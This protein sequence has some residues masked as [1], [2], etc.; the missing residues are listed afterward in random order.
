M[1][2]YVKF[3]ENSK[4]TLIYKHLTHSDLISSW[5]RTEKQGLEKNILNYLSVSQMQE[6][7]NNWEEFET[8][9]QSCITIPKS[10]FENKLWI[11][12]SRSN[13]YYIDKLASVY[14]VTD[15]LI[16]EKLHH[17]F[18]KMRIE[19]EKIYFL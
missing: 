1:Y 11:Q 4:F 7:K 6:L 3:H 17:E 9:H 19:N 18:S 13:Q 14:L 2:D 10:I 16:Y 15:S 5:K 12:I 8:A